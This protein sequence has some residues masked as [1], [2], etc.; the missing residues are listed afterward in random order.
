M[1]ILEQKEKV[2]ALLIKTHEQY[3]DELQDYIYRKNLHISRMKRLA[4]KRDLLKEL[5]IDLNL[6]S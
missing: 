6:R 1:T 2:K 4:R 5:E 3:M